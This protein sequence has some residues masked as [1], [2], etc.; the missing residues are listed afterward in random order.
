MVP[1][2]G[3]N[4][5]FKWWRYIGCAED[6]RSFV[7]KSELGLQSDQGALH[8]TRRKKLD[9]EDQIFHLGE[10]NILDDILGLRA[11]SSRSMLAYDLP[12]ARAVVHPT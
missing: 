6:S 10:L 2:H 12:Y 9:D 1:V 8:G 11:S 7:W 5:R 4:K 3:C